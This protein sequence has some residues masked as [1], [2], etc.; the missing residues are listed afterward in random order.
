MISSVESGGT[1]NAFRPRRRSL[2]PR[3]SQEIDLSRELHDHVSQ[4]L[5]LLLLEMELFKADQV[6]R[7]GVLREV[8][9]M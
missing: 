7:A 5:N 4:T 2:R 3:P 6:G 9:R 1:A 8:D